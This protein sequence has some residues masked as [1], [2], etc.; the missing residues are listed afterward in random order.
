MTQSGDKHQRQKQAEAREES[1]DLNLRSLIL[2]GVAVVAMIVA[3]NVLVTLLWGVL[4]PRFPSGSALDSDEIEP[5]FPAPRLQSAPGREM[6]ELR[7]T[8]EARL[9]S[10]ALEDGR[11]RIPIRQA[12]EMIAEQ[13][14]DLPP[15]GGVEQPGETAPP[16]E[17]GEAAG[18]G[19]ALFQELGC[20]GCH[21]AQDTSIAPSLVGVAGETVPLE[22][23]STITA[24]EEYLRQSIV[25]PLAHIVQGYQPIMP[26]FADRVDDEQLAALVAYIQ[27]L[28]EE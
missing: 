12:M 19:E 5:A 25:E 9:N 6:T 16:G 14:P 1:S 15:V 13:G 3:V 24:D 2:A 27:S 11:A 18:Q 21:M 8:Q 20:G 10:Y 7:A 28:G 26:S 4:A 23:G 17:G 22:D